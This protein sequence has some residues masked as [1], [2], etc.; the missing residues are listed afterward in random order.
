MLTLEEV[1][2]RGVSH[3]SIIS[4]LS[5]VCT[6]VIVYDDENGEQCEHQVPSKHHD[7][8]IIYTGL[9]YVIMRNDDGTT[10]VFN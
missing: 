9:K 8:V 3:E 4:V 1:K 6:A 2:D 7:D 10:V 5:S